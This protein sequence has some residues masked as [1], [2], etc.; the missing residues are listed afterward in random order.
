MRNIPRETWD[1]TRL[2]LKH[3]TDRISDIGHPYGSKYYEQTI[4]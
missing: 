4:L 2:L 1:H 3:W